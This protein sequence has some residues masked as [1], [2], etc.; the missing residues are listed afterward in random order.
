[1]KESSTAK[2]RIGNMEYTVVRLFS[3]EA[4]VEDIIEK[5]AWREHMKQ[6]EKVRKPFTEPAEYDIINRE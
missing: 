4:T 6:K 1:M 5:L 2:Y 3:Q